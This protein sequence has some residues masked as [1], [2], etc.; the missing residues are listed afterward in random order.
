MFRIFSPRIKSWKRIDLG[1]LKSKNIFTT[2]SN[3]QL[4]FKRRLMLVLKMKT[5][6]LKK[7]FG[8]ILLYFQTF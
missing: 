1:D 5:T 6:N 2:A 4:Y 7:E 3:K 8:M